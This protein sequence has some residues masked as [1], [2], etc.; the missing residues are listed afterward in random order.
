MWDRGWRRWSRACFTGGHNRRLTSAGFRGTL[1]QAGYAAQFTREPIAARISMN[2]TPD[3]CWADSVYNATV[4][5]RGGFDV[6][7]SYPAI[8]HCKRTEAVL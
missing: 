3:G 1:H 2:E 8:E 5:G 7:N 6:Q 4:A